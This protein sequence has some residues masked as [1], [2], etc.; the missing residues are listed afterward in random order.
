MLTRTFS[1]ALVMV[2]VAS[3]AHAQAVGVEVINSMVDTYRDSIVGWEPKLEALALGTFK[4][5]ATAGFAWAIIKQVFNRA[6]FSSILSTVLNQVFFIGFWYFILTST[7]TWGAQIINSCLQAAGDATGV[8]VMHPGD[9]FNAGWTLTGKMLSKKFGWDVVLGLGLIITGVI[10]MFVFALMT[11]SMILT[12]ID[13][14]IVIAAGVLILSF[15]GIVFTVDIAMSMLRST[16]AAGMKLFTQVCIVAL[17]MNI[18]TNAIDAFDPEADVNFQTLA[19]IIGTAV[20]L[21]VVAHF[22][23][24]RVEAIVASAQIAGGGELFGTAMAVGATGL[25][26]A[27]TAG[28]AAMAA[29]GAARAVGNWGSGASPSVTSQ[30]MSRFSGGRRP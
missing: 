15:S 19:G 18:V 25:T 20:V 29:G 10:I 30:V 17:G 8:S 1:L 9:I 11:A 22:S 26:A 7:S 2:A 16:L 28:R 6:D 21:L 3:G 14:Y 24:R 5:L 27:S 12:L 13:V 23:P 4:I